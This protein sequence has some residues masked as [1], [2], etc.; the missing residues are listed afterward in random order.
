MLAGVIRHQ[1]ICYPA[2][3]ASSFFCAVCTSSPVNFWSYTN[4]SPDDHT[5]PGCNKIL[6]QKENDRLFYKL[7]LN[8]YTWACYL[9]F[10]WT[11]LMIFL[12]VITNTM[13]KCVWDDVP[14][15]AVPKTWV[16][17]MNPYCELKGSAAFWGVKGAF[18]CVA[19]SI[20][21]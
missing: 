16:C 7:I 14:D 11:S 18:F 9:F 2:F 8:E 15:L 17:L 19:W 20:H 12:S 5:C 10:H 21:L 1:P 6:L 4:Q 3:S 13:R